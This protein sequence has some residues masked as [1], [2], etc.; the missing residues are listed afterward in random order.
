MRTTDKSGSARGA[1]GKTAGIWHEPPALTLD[2]N[3]LIM[4]CNDGGAEFFGYSRK[5]LAHQHISTVLPQLSRM[6]LLKGSEPNAEFSFMC[7]IGYA[8][9]VIP[10]NGTAILCGLSVV[11]LSS[12]GQTLMRL[13]VKV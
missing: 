9:E 5:E 10:R 1:D 11:C 7:R 6:E 13:I 12:A 4:E 8:F 3:G 2:K